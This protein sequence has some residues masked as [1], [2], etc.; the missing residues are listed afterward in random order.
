MTDLIPL[1]HCTICIFKYLIYIVYRLCI[2]LKSSKSFSTLISLH[3]KN[4]LKLILK[5]FL[6]ATH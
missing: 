2:F 5:I 1:Y 6:D 3:P 4:I